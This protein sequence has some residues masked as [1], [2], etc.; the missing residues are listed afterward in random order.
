MLNRMLNRMLKKMLIISTAAAA[1]ADAAADS[2]PENTS[3]EEEEN[4]DTE[5]SSCSFRFLH[6]SF[7]PLT[8]GIGAE[9]GDK[10]SFLQ[11]S[12]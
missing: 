4:P 3:R 1:A 2:N 8:Q 10:S 11:E 12:G 9:T 7:V 5:R 6:T